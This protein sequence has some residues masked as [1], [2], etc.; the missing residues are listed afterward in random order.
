MS[1]IEL[2]GKKHKTHKKFVQSFKVHPRFNP[3]GILDEELK[4]NFVLSVI[5]R[6]ERK[7]KKTC[8]FQFFL[9]IEIDK[10]VF[11]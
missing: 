2:F 4:T 11:F 5:V 3:R 6:T 9:Y 10:N 1:L 8:F 7:R